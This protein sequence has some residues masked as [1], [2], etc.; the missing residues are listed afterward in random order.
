MLSRAPHLT[1]RRGLYI[2]SVLIA[3]I[4]LLICPLH[5][6]WGSSKGQW[7]VTLWRGALLIY[8]GGMPLPEFN[9]PRVVFV[10]EPLVWLPEIDRATPIAKTVIPLWP[11]VIVAGGL[12]LLAWYR[13]RHRRDRRGVDPDS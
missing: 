1:L 9:G 3:M 13:A 4:W 8:Q 5:V 11:L 2:A 10:P 12:S 6:S 7:V